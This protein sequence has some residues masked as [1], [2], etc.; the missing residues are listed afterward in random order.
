M[1]KHVTVRTE[2]K[3]D[4]MDKLIKEA[5]KGN[6][7]AF[8]QLIQMQMQNMY[9]TAR[10]LLNNDEDVAD[11]MSETVLTCWEKLKQLKHENY[12]RTWMTRILINKCLE[13]NAEPSF[14]L[15]KVLVDGKE[16]FS[17][18]ASFY[19][20]LIMGENGTA[21]YANGKPL[22]M[23]E[24]NG[25][26]A[27]YVMEDG[28]LEFKVTLV[29]TREIGYFI[30]KP[31]HVELGNL[32]TAQK[33]EHI[34]DID[35]NWNFDWVLQGSEDMKTATLHVPLGDTNAT[36]V[37]AHISPVSLYV[38]YEFPINKIKETVIDENGQEIP[39]TLN[40]E[41]PQLAGVKMKDG[42]LYT[43]LRG[44]GSDGYKFEN[45]DIYYTTFATNRILDV[46]QIE[47]LL[48]IKSTTENENSFYEVPIK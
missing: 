6:P 39:V 47:C 26:T 40:A 32:G 1:Q 9:K 12:F 44:A 13:Q 2:Y 42:T 28:S 45:A 19:D 46:E 25:I 36:V 3:G 20:G 10:A 18:T 15:I 8:T 24:N 14:D 41:P 34:A 30:D 4:H 17:Y 38:E 22:E 33:A 35:G 21:I 43:E 31:I 7:D 37:K 48:F 5:K 11:A 29:N 27:N 23:N 16:D